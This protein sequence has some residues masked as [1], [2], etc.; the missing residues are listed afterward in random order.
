MFIA[1]GQDESFIDKLCTY[2]HHRTAHTS[3][4]R[5]SIIHMQKLLS[6][7]TLVLIGKLDLES[8]PWLQRVHIARSVLTPISSLSKE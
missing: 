8:I 1:F 6:P 5:G 2:P 3:T 7:A 4:E